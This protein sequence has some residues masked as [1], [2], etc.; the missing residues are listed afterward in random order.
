MRPWGRLGRYLYDQIEEYNLNN[1]EP[2]SLRRGENWPLGDSPTA[3]VLLTTERRGNF[4][5]EKAP[6]VNDD[7]TYTQNPE[8]KDIRVYDYVDP[9][10]ILEDFYAKGEK[11]YQLY[12]PSF[13]NLRNVKAYVQEYA[14][15]FEKGWNNDMDV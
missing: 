14:C 6:L 8:G 10:M 5:T 3:G 4:H 7:M 2:V 12:S 11:K 9:S 13:S 15:S 1:D